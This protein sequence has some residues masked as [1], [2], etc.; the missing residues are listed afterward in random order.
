MALDSAEGMEFLMPGRQKPGQN[1]RAPSRS[2]IAQA[3]RWAERRLRRMSLD[4]KL[5]QLFIVRAW[6][7]FTSSEDPS[8]RDL[9]RI[10]SEGRAGGVMIEAQRTRTGIALAQAYPTTAVICELQRRARIPLLVGADFETGAAM[11]ISEGTSL[12]HAMAVAAT[13]DPRDAYTA[14]KI[15]ALEARAVGVNWIYA[16]VAD[17]NSNPANPIINIRSFG[18]RP[19]TVSRFVEEFVRGAEENGVLATAKHFPGHGDTDV[20]SHSGLPVI[21]ASRERLERME[22]APFRAAIRAGVGSIMTG[23]LLVPA[24]EP[25]PSLPATLSPNILNGLLRR[26]MGFRGLIVSD[27][28][29]MAGVALRYPVNRSAALAIAAGADLLLNPIDLSAATESLRAA[30]RDA[31]ISRA[32]ID[33][34]VR[35]ILTTKARVAL[36]SADSADLTHLAGRFARPGFARSAL[37]IA[38]RGIVLLRDTQSLVPLDEAKPFRTLLVAISADPDPAPGDGIEDALRERLGSLDVLRADT[39]FFP[40][41]HFELPGE[42]SYD[43]AVVAITIRVA[44]RKGSVALPNDLAEMVERVLVRKKPAIVLAFGSPYLISRFPSAKTWL[45]AMSTQPVAELAMAATLLGE[46]PIE[47][48]LP[49]E[50]PGVAALGA[51]HALSAKPMTLEKAPVAMRAA[52][53]PAG[54]ILKR[55]IAERAFPGAVLA[56]GHE[57]R[58]ALQGFGRFTY[59]RKSPAAKPATIYDAASLTKVVVTTTASMQ[60]V[61]KGALRLDAPVAHYL[62]GW[63]DAGQTEWRAKVT[64]A[65][66]LRHS[67]GLCAHREFYRQARGRDAVVA[68]AL[69]ETLEYEPGTSILY[70]DLGFILLGDIL[71]RIAGETLEQ[72]AKREIFEPLGMNDSMFRPPRRL[73]T[74]IAPTENDADWRK[75]QVWGE[76][77][78][79][80]A[81]AM[82]GVAGHAGLFSTASDLAIFCQMILNGGVYAHHRILRRETI[83]RF[84]R[85]KAIGDSAR[86]LGWDVST[87]ESSSGRYFSRNSF[88]HTGYTGTSIWIDPEKQLFVVLLTN[89]VYP[90]AE[91]NAIRQLRPALHDAVVRALGLVRES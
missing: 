25:D 87:G 68:R 1:Q 73:R 42:S 26:E 59:S 89:R 14:G 7:R 3:A 48:R 39:R 81:A 37:D 38:S 4:E 35:R 60:M 36:E 5:G 11:R 20:D 64:V 79:S 15:T 31:L 91:N 17:L 83:D 88:G 41:K 66:L 62:P 54:E 61:E 63:A 30:V 57:N 10:V 55:A 32:Q 18:E 8:F 72:Y 69:A 45:S 2:A 34:A 51:G 65:D 23:H 74:K 16:P 33:A 12:P 80:N 27:S 76:V 50:I 52:L 90:S 21:S 71:E 13:G 86:S 28:L 78:D 24:L 19:E 46:T 22:F 49:V 9:A 75:R 70:S 40:A 29:D 84:T 53:S 56:V 58:L 77:H 43:L 47:G 67:A 85:R 44:D 82:G 6:G